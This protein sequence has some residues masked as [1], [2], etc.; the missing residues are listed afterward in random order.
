MGITVSELAIGASRTEGELHASR[1]RVDDEWRARRGE[2]PER[3]HEDK[4]TKW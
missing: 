3:T 4:R 1:R 2:D